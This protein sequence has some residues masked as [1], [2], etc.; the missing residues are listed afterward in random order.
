[1]FNSELNQVLAYIVRDIRIGRFKALAASGG[2]AFD[3]P[4]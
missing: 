1:M 4:A 2:K 3:Q